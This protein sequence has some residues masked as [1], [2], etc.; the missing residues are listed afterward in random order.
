MNLLNWQG[1]AVTF[2]KSIRI[3]PVKLIKL[4]L[5]NTRKHGL[6]QMFTSYYSFVGHTALQ[7]SAC[8]NHMVPY[9]STKRQ[10]SVKQTNLQFFFPELATLPYNSPSWISTTQPVV[11]IFCWN[12]Y[13]RHNVVSIAAEFCAWSNHHVFNTAFQL[14]HLS[15]LCALTEC[16]SGNSSSV[17]H[18]SPFFWVLCTGVFIISDWNKRIEYKP[19]SGSIPLFPSIHLETCDGPVSSI[20][21]TLELQ[22]NYIG[23]GCDRETY[24]EKSLQK[25][26]GTCLVFGLLI[27]SFYPDKALPHPPHSP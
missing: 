24:S 17:N 12:M 8:D 6:F 10:L 18:Q 16:N 25:L 26:C 9:N 5:V 2:F 1:K 14:P 23:K 13:L 20:Q 22:T 11:F 15:I 3:Q 27:N 19:G 21:T 7:L 4:Y